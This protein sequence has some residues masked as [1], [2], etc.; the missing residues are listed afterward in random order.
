[1]SFDTH[2]IHQSGSK[3]VEA[4]HTGFAEQFMK[5]KTELAELLRSASKKRAK[6]SE[7]VPCCV[8]LNLQLWMSNFLLSI[9]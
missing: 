7:V 3:T 8:I 2:S 9:L 4:H 5:R 6:T 1:M